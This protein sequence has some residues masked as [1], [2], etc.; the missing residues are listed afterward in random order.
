MNEIMAIAG[1]TWRRILRMRVVYFLVVCVLILIGSA[2][3]YDVLSMGEHKP[4]M[5]DVSLVLNTVAAVL[6]AISITFEI[7]KELREGVA[8]TLL[9]KPLGRTQYLIGKLIGTIITGVVITAMIAVGFFLI[10]SVAFNE[11][12][13]KAIVQGQLLV[14]LS[15]IPMS[16][17]AVLFSVFIPEMLTALVTAAVIWLAHSTSQLS[18]V[19]ILYGGIIPDLDLFNLKS[20]AVYGTAIHWDYILLTL[21][22]GIVF[23]VFAIS[24]ASLI[25]NYKDLK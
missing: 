15:V 13:A 16:A 10:Y 1:G 14:I 25:F 9:S 5:I 19:M 23:S 22:W 2:V 21:V 24:V 12:I 4:L 7:P 11:Q 6:V 18:N 8:S 17:I 3:N 20:Q